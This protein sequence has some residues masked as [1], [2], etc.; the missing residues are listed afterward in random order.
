MR[1]GTCEWRLG[2]PGEGALFH[3]KDG[4]RGDDLIDSEQ[5]GRRALPVRRWIGGNVVI[6][7]L[8]DRITKG[9]ERDAR[10]RQAQRAAEN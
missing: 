6:V 7:I 9:E 1:T 3:S 5:A 2:R 4:E 10:Y 8:H